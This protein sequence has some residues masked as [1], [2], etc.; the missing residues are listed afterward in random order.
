MAGVLYWAISDNQPAGVL[1]DV[2]HSVAEISIDGCAFDE[3]VPEG[4]A[5]GYEH[6]VES[7]LDVLLAL[8]VGGQVRINCVGATVLEPVSNMCVSCPRGIRV[9]G[10]VAYPVQSAE[11]TSLSNSRLGW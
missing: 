6:G 5:L 2:V 10:M 9:V 1:D 11:C 7:H 3:D 8:G 4:V